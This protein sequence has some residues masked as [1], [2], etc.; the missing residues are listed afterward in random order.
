MPRAIYDRVRWPSELRGWGGSEAAISLKA[1]FLGIPILHLCGPLTR[2]LFKKSFQYQVN[3]E[4]VAWNHAVIARVC[5]DER[6][7]MEYWLP[8]VFAKELPESILRELDSPA[9]RDEQREF[10][11]KKVRSDRDFWRWL[12]KVPEPACLRRTSI[13]PGRSDLR[14]ASVRPG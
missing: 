1:F 10:E 2:H 13:A 5:F 6:T 11:R 8:H 4:G 7:W 9:I 12:L 3:S 14:F